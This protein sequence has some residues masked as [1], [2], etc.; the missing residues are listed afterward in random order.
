M[1]TEPITVRL[2]RTAKNKGGDRYE[3]I[4]DNNKFITYI[5]QYISRKDGEAKEIIKI[6]FELVN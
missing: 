6:H 3:G 2:T 4:V 5:P 1:E